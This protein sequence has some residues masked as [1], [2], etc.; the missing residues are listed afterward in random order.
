MENIEIARIFEDV[1]DLLEMLGAS[2]FRIRAYRAAAR[3]V[4]TLGTPAESLLKKDVNALE[5][6]PGIG[7]DLAGK[8]REIIETQWVLLDDDDGDIFNGSPHFAEIDGAK[9]MKQ[10]PELAVSSSSACTS[11]LLQPSYVLGAMGCDDAR[12]RGSV[13]FSLG[14]FNTVDQID[15]A[16]A[17]VADA[18]TALRGQRP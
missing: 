5:A 13:R 6:L 16:V 7:K 4:E 18:V 17:M 15:T 12:I 2:V 9:L 8:I 10:M 1:A 3:T 11:A 14:R